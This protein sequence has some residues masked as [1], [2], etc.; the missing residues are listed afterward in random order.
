MSKLLSFGYAQNED[1][2]PNDDDAS[3][4]SSC[5]FLLLYHEYF[6]FC[7]VLTTI[8]VG[9]SCSAPW[10]EMLKSAVSSF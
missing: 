9:G 2:S 4:E 6:E 1:K 3:S 8:T 10:Y 5:F 7:I